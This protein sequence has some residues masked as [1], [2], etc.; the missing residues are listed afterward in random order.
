MSDGKTKK[1]GENWPL[2]TK[3]AATTLLSGILLAAGL[4]AWVPMQI[5]Q[6]AQD[7]A[8]REA[9]SNV[10][11]IK[12]LRGYYTRNIVEPA[13][14]L[15][16]L[17]AG[18]DHEGDDTKIPLPA[19]MVHDL[20]EEF[21]EGRTLRLYSNYPFPNRA[22]RKLDRFEE[23]AWQKLSAAPGTNVSVLEEADGRSILRLAVADTMSAASCILPQRAPSDAKGRLGNWGRSRRPRD[24][25][26]PHRERS[27]P[28][29][30][31]G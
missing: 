24:K 28:V 15:G 16:T 14:K 30:W 2:S 5:A 17:S 9:L 4:A 10:T 23:D 20:S 26:R 27:Q 19:T 18:V 8:A 12:Q 3:V 21:S 31:V 29:N 7:L 1:R 13:L 25:G 11:Q 6:V 22:D